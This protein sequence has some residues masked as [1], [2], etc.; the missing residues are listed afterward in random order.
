LPV[1]EVAQLIG[2]ISY[3]ILCSLGRSIPRTYKNTTEGFP[4]EGP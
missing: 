1:E 2:T 3:E 4:V